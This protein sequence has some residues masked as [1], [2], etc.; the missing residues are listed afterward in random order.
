MDRIKLGR[1]G[2]ERAGEYLADQGLV[3]REKNFRCKLGEIDLIAMDGE[4][5]VFIEVKT[6]TSVAYGFPMEAVGRRKQE[7]YI[8]MASVYIK[9]RG[10][11]GVPFRFDIVEVLTRDY[12]PPIINHIPNAFQSTGGRYYL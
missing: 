12:E 2:E 9:A 3:V 1:W 5:L 8:Q 4:C 11:Y 10:L 6:R 7:K